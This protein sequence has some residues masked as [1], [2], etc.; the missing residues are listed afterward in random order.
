MRP[1]YALLY[2]VTVVLV[3][4]TLLVL[5]LIAYTLITRG[6]TYFQPGATY[7]PSSLVASH[8]SLALVPTVA[9]AIWGQIP[10][11]SVLQCLAL[12]R[13]RGCAEVLSGS[14]VLNAATC[15]VFSLIVMVAL[16][17]SGDIFRL[18]AAVVVA[19]VVAPV[20]ALRFWWRALLPIPA[21]AA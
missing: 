4:Y 7:G 20:I 9:R 2:C 14:T 11:N 13:L 21:A 16:P 10:I 15:I 6:S 19:S 17:N 5:G 3:D 8:A 1:K 12:G 18:M